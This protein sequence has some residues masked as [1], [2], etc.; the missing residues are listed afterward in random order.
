M[1]QQDNAMVMSRHASERAQQRGITPDTLDLLKTY[2]RR[3]YDHRGAYS[4]VFDRQAREKIMKVFG[5]AA[6]QLNFNAYAVVASDSAN[7]VV[8][9]GHR[10][11]RVREYC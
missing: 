7:L 6:A 5:K 2:G 9:A 3:V 11:R 4:L 8:T 1:P 10:T